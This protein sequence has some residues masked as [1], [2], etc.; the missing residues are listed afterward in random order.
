MRAVTRHAAVT[1]YASTA[2]PS[3]TPT[4]FG[5]SLTSRRAHMA[6]LHM[7]HRRNGQYWLMRAEPMTVREIDRCLSANSL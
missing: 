7:M 1:N 3:I 4:L 6:G 5:V 2:E